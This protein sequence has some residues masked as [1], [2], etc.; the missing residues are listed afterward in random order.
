MKQDVT[1]D[2]TGCNTNRIDSC[3]DMKQ[4]NL[5]MNLLYDEM[6]KADFRK[7]IISSLDG[8][9]LLLYYQYLF[10]CVNLYKR[11]F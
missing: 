3:Q 1:Q 9:L 8:N 6:I 4:Q 7:F 10:E 5:G 2:G 11:V